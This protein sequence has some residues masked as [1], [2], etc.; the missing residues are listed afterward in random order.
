MQSRQ[1]LS[2]PLPARHPDFNLGH[3]KGIRSIEE[4]SAR[5]PRRS[6]RALSH[7]AADWGSPGAV[8]GLDDLGDRG[9]WLLPLLK[10]KSDLTWEVSDQKANCRHDSESCSTFQEK[11]TKAEKVP[12]GRSSGV[13]VPDR[14]EILEIH[15]ACQQVPLQAV[16]ASVL[17]DTY[18][19]QP[20]NSG[21]GI[22]QRCQMLAFGV[23]TSS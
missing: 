7:H 8:L 19:L 20:V 10:R 6:W 13:Q 14:K 15:S 5:I 11:C 16:S 23:K 18:L 21:H 4:R 9:Q 2:C 22:M 17:K 1:L 3:H 12:E